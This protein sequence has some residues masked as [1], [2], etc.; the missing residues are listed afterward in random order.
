MTIIDTIGAAATA[1]N[2]FVCEP[3]SADQ[4]MTEAWKGV[5]FAEMF[6]DDKISAGSAAGVD[7]EQSLTTLNTKKSVILFISLI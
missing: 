3:F 1:W 7:E 2:F 4:E 6:I 5:L